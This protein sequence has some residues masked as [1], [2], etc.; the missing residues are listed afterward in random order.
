M[1]FSAC[2]LPQAYINEFDLE[3]FAHERLL[4][5]VI[6][7]FQCSCDIILVSEED[8]TDLWIVVSD[9]FVEMIA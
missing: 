5:G 2:L 7:L 3:Q 8:I 1:Y 6:H 4:R 9:K